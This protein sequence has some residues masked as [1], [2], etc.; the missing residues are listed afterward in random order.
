MSSVYGLRLLAK[1]RVRLTIVVLIAAIVVAY[2]AFQLAYLTTQPQWGYDLSF[3][4][5]AAQHLI[6]GE[7]IYSLAQLS[8]PY[9]PQGQ[10]GFLYPPPFAAVM[11][12]LAALT[13]DARAAEWI[14]SALGVAVLVTSVLALARSERI[15]ERLAMLRG[16]GRWLLVA[17]ALAFPPV[18]GELSIGNVHLLL[19]S[20]FTLAWLGIRRRD[21]AGDAMAGFGLGAAALIKVFP[22]VLLLWLVAT[23]RYRA[24]VAMVGA[25]VALVLVTLPFTGIEPWLQYPRVLGNLSAVYDTTDTIS[26]AIWLAPYLGFT[27][28]RWLVLGIGVVIVV[29]SALR[30]GREPVPAIS[31]ATAVVVSVLIAP[32]IFHHYL[33]IFVL[34]MILGLA[35]GVPL[36][37]LAFA[38]L[39][40]SGGQQPALGELA[41]IVNRVL[42]TT[43]TLVLLGSLLLARVRARPEEPQ[44]RTAAPT[45][46]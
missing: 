30:G 29:W 32:N 39:L 13:P 20:L 34:P 24:A 17:A 28:A 46:P 4:W 36:P 10:D 25:G 41:W 6:H 23:R 15:G 11:I 40:M 44:S 31:F 35:A 18:I 12:P 22:G 19:L 2:R 16:R 33:A 8:G 26:P 45:S 43:G 42:P 1:P 9:A 3:Y 7:P 38:Y 14:W 5:T 37:W 21:V 27:T